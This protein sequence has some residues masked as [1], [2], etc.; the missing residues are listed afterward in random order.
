MKIERQMNDK[1]KNWYMMN[2]AYDE[3]AWE[4]RPNITFGKLWVGMKEGKDVYRLLGVCDSW[5]RE[6]VFNELARRLNVEYK[7]VYDTWLNN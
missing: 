2:H 7:V 1:I 4:L 6:I 5:I 3:M